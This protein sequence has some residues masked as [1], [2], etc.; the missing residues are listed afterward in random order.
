MAVDKSRR[1]AFDEVAE[2]YDNVRPGYPEQLIKDVV[3]LSG[4]PQGGRILE[5]GCGPGQATMPFA[6]RGYAM[7]GLELGKNLALLV[8]R[9]SRPYPVVEIQNVSFEEWALE[10]EAFDLVIS[11]HAFHW[12]PAEIGY[13]KAAAALKDS[14]W[15]ALFWHHHP[16]PDTAFSRALDEVYRSKAPQ[17]TGSFKTRH[18]DEL[19]E[20]VEA[21]NASG[22]Y[23]Q[24]L[25]RRY[26]WSEKYTAEQYME[27]LS[28]YSDHRRLA[29]ETRRNLFE[30]VRELIEEHGGVVNKPYLTVLYMAK[31]ERII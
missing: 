3:A 14:G 1:T 28:T 17:P 9:K 16:D 20:T 25:V 27:L 7:L 23:G 31:V 10:R 13:A 24:V 2:L 15:I 6:R 21:I 11:A 4:I 30:S 26:P 8:A 19:V 12:I 22:K 29:E 18:P 5:I